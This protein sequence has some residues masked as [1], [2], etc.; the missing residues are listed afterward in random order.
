M[1]EV[2]IAAILEPT[3]KETSRRSGGAAWLL[4]GGLALLWFVVAVSGLSLFGA[5]QNREG[6]RGAVPGQ[7]PAKSRISRSTNGSTLLVFLH[8]NC[9]CSRASVH[10][11]QRI[12]AAVPTANRP[13]TIFVFRRAATDDWRVRSLLADAAAATPDATFLQ[14]F[15]LQESARFGTQVSGH[16]LVYDR[17]GQLVFDGGITPDRGQEG[18]SVSGTRL[19]DALADSTGPAAHTAVFGCSLQ[20]PQANP[21]KRDPSCATR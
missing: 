19:Y 9:P 12:L 14:D 13:R 16:V 1:E 18:E 17:A 5:Y 8:P 2:T 10:S 11:L 4:R 6:D 21:A 20:T 7:W 15:D 3:Q